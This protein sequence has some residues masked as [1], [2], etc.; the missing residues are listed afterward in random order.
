MMSMLLLVFTQVLSSILLLAFIAP[1]LGG[2][3]QEQYWPQIQPITVTTTQFVYSTTTPS[4][5]SV[6]TAGLNSTMNFTSAST[7]VSAPLAIAAEAYS[8]EMPASDFGTHSSKSDG[9][10][11]QTAIPVA[12][13]ESPD[14]WNYAY[15]AT[16]SAFASSYRIIFGSYHQIIAPLFFSSQPRLCQ[17]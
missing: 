10:D 13:L 16:I 8:P 9:L 7:T 1:F 11:S 2:F 15:V 14:L 6:T 12:P 5:P 17:I 3:D 4:L